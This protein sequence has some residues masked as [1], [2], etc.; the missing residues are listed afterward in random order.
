[1]LTGQPGAVLIPQVWKSGNDE[2]Q[3]GRN[4]G[5]E[6]LLVNVTLDLSTWLCFHVLSLVYKPRALCLVDVLDQFQTVAVSSL[7]GASC[8]TGVQQLKA[9]QGDALLSCLPLFL[10]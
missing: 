4:P 5:A 8:R 9:G 2:N 7:G 6:R 1:M 10:C 3:L